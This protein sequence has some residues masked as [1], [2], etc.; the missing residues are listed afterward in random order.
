MSESRSSVSHHR[1]LADE[2]GQRIDN[3]LL[4][5][6]KGVPRS[7]VYRLLR[8]GEVRIDGARVRP[9]AR[10]EAGQ[11]VRIPPVTQAARPEGVAGGGAAARL[12][13][14]LLERLRHAVLYEDERLIVLNKPSGLA[15][16]GGSTVRLG[17]IEALRQLRPQLPFVELAHRLDQETSG[18]L[19][20]AKRRS[21]LRR[22]HAQL[23]DGAV[24]KQYTALL[25][26]TLA[27]SHYRIDAPLER[28][29]GAGHERQVWVSEA[30]RAART[31]LQ[32]R[33]SY[34][35]GEP[36][37]GGG[38]SLVDVDLATGRTHQIRVHCAHIGHPVAGDARY[39]EHAANAELRRR[40]GLRRLFLH[41]SGVAFEH[42]DHGTPLEVVAPLSEDLQRALARLDNEQRIEES[43]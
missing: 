18:C 16:H 29:S 3:F 35:V 23:R 30:G 34:V 32:L 27:E 43:P 2:A 17:L 36:V 33:R 1:V 11:L 25:V 14:A 24:R 39:G 41:A 8:R 22:L 15:V 10:L 19:I 9:T 4:R 13:A 12:P 5:R 6:L 40:C 28:R 31:E 7:R 42:P 20:L 21:T 38:V 37:I 26:G